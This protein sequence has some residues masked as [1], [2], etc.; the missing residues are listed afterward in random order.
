MLD[1]LAVVVEPVATKV[2]K[3]LKSQT[4]DADARTRHVKVGIPAKPL[5][6]RTK[7]FTVTQR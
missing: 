2:E 3:P 4:V 1:Q 6:F 7:H 5:G